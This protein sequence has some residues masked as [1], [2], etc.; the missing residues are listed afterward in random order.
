[1]DL[2]K[3][4]D[5]TDHEVSMAKSELY[6]LAKYSIKLLKM[7]EQEQELEGWVQ[8]KITKAA[9]Y[10]GSVYH[11][12]DYEKT[13]KPELKPNPRKYDESVHNNVV[14]TLSD[15]WYNYKNQG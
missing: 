1:M 5:P 2:D 7:I 13:V 10:I 14:S 8:S 15:Q 3:E 6:R 11:H 12:L 9:D 4:H